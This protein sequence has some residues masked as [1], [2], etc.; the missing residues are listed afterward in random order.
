MY[1]HVTNNVRTMYEHVTNNLRTL[2]LERCPNMEK[3]RLSVVHHEHSTSTAFSG[4]VFA[5]RI[6]ELHRQDTQVNTQAVRVV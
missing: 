5:F 4:V 1:E 6:L 2:P 3:S